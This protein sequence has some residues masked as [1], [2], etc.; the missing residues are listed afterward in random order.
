MNALLI[1][2]AL[3]AI[4]FSY[5]FFVVVPEGKVVIITSFGKFSRIRSA[6]F[7]FKWPVIERVAK[8]ISLQNLSEELAFQAITSDQANVGFKTL[9]LY[10]VHDNSHENIYKVAYKFDSETMFRQTLFRSIEST[11]RAFVATKRQVEILALRN[12]IINEVKTNLDSS[13]ADWGYK[14]LD[15]QINEI[16]FDQTIMTSMAEVVASQNLKEAAYNKGEATLVQRTKEAEAEGN[17]IRIAAEAEK[18]AA[19]LRGQGTALF[20]EEVAK[21]ISKAAVEIE[22]AGLDA[23]FVS[24]SM[25]LE[26]MRYIAKEG[27]GNFMTFDG[28][29]TGEK[30]LL[31][32]LMA[33]NVF[34]KENL[35]DTSK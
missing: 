5:G 4:V 30:A 13:I 31:K 29:V 23:S 21:G 14:L 35:N 19:Q 7:H 9:V 34:D 28:S 2:I 24:F 3:F 26:S 17:A 20:R 12:E 22:A 8:F 18:V 6:G 10:A 1:L 25:W 15:L 33:L 11:V 27:K 32:E 16:K